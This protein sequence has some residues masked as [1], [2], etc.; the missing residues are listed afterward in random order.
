MTSTA[1]MILLVVALATPL[2]F[3][4]ADT[5]QLAATRAQLER[6]RAEA[7][8]LMKSQADLYKQLESIDRALELSSRL[9]RQLREQSLD[10]K[11]EIAATEDTLRSLQST[12]AT[13]S[14]LAARRLRKVFM[15]HEVNHFDIP[16]LY[17]SQIETERQSHLTARLI[18]S[19]S[20][21]LV[22][23]DAAITDK[24]AVLANLQRRQEELAQNAKARAAEE[25]RARA[26]LRQRETL[27]ADLKS[28]SRD[29]A[30]QVDQIGE[31]STALSEV[32]AQ[33]DAQVTGT[34]DFI[35][36][37][38][39]ELNLKM[40]GRLFW[41][42]TGPVVNKFGLSRDSRSGLTSKSNGVV[43]ATNRGAKVV[44]ALTGEVIYIGWARGLERFVVVD[45]GGSIYT[46]YGNLDRID[47]SEGQQVIRGE[48]FAVTAG[49]RLHFEVR[50]G[51]TPVD[52]N[53]WLRH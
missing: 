19:D 27:L 1:A 16:Y 14:E 24:T 34:G 9:Q 51:K 3:G 15:L 5:S 7:E 48:A 6:A 37:R 36:Q 35:W 53:A 10:L 52:P 33:I 12:S 20:R 32:F 47:V 23:I 39:R 4:Q 45:H 41:P 25:Q 40:K 29:L 46:V 49:S 30:W 38:E 13:A 43:I 18:R 26:A 8:R 42:V 17:S 44:A 11:A 22:S 50:E 31:S 28:E 2:L 21:Q